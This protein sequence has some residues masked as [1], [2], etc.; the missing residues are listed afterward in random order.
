MPYPTYLPQSESQSRSPSACLAVV[1]VQGNTDK[2]EHTSCTNSAS[3]E[4][5]PFRGLKEPSGCW[6]LG[7]SKGPRFA[8]TVL[9]SALLNVL[10]DPPAGGSEGAERAPPNG[11]T[12]I[13]NKVRGVSCRRGVR[14]CCC[15]LCG[16]SV[17]RV[18]TPRSGITRAPGPG[19][20][21][22]CRGSRIVAPPYRSARCRCPG[23]P[24]PP[25]RPI[26]YAL[27]SH[28]TRGP[29]GGGLE[30]NSCITPP[31]RH[32]PNAF[33]LPEFS[34]TLVTAVSIVLKKPPDANPNRGLF[35]CPDHL[36]SSQTK[37]W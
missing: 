6:S 8:R 23:L 25:P 11:K 32:T 13:S 18:A 15:V 24:S 37:H 19:C 14:R 34:S 4:F 31:E 35:L 36:S 28:Y 5:S 2:I 20:S 29:A 1:Q 17:S 33:A 9:S 16:R 3:W 27:W 22:A 26:G 21:V 12:W 7:S 10:F 30:G